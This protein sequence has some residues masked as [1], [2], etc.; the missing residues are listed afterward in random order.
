MWR[1]IE[2]IREIFFAHSA[3]HPK[4]WRMPV[5]PVFA[6]PHGTKM[7]LCARHKAHR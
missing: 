4:T 7:G 5:W 1:E 2:A 3:M 6:P